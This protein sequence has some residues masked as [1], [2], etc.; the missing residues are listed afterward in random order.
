MKTPEEIKKALAC[1][2]QERSDHLDCSECAY[3]GKDLTP[4]RIAVHE[5]ALAYMEQ[6]EYENM[7]MKIQ[8]RGDCGV[9]KHSGVQI[10][11]EPCASC[12]L[13]KDRPAW[14]D[15]GLPELPDA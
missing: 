2:V 3:H 6:L 11:A 7:A 12:V 1:P 5:D 8:R 4:C 10:G 15:M 13:E 14:D 9:C